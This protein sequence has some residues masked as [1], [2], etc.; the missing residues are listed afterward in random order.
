MR[1]EVDPKF[2]DWCLYEKKEREIWIQTRREEGHVKTQAETGVMLTQVKER[3]RPLE[4]GRS[5]EEFFPT[6]FKDSMALL[7]LDF[8]P[9]ASRT[10][11]E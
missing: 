11:T 10:V 5:K 1:S 3:L 2:N 4:A 7:T 9:L 8:G 6:A